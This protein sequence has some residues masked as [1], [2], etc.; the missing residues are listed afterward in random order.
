[1]KRKQMAQQQSFHELL[2]QEEIKYVG[3]QMAQQQ[4]FHELLH[5]EE[6]KYVGVLLS[7]SLI[8]MKLM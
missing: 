2:H 8:L 4:S 6:I 1:M 3:V 5:Q 7:S